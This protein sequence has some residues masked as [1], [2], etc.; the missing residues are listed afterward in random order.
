MSDEADHGLDDGGDVVLAAGLGEEGVRHLLVE[1]EVAQLE[2]GNVAMVGDE[3][4]GLCL[5]G[6]VG[7]GGGEG[8]DHGLLVPFGRREK[9]APQGWVGEDAPPAPRAL[10]DARAQPLHGLAV[11]VPQA[12]ADKARARLDVDVVARVGALATGAR[13]GGRVMQLFSSA[14]FMIFFF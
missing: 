2:Q 4:L 7:V 12:A 3:P 13:P 11:G 8:L 6:A 14:S 10:V 5:E 1:G 9:G